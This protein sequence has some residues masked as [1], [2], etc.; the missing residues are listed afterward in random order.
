MQAGFQEGFTYMNFV[1]VVGG[2]ESGEKSAHAMVAP[3]IDVLM[4]GKGSGLDQQDP[5]ETEG[6]GRAPGFAQLSTG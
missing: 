4:W 3:R 2:V 1:E 5:G 6:E